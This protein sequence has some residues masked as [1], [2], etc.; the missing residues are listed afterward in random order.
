MHFRGIIMLL[1][2]RQARMVMLI[3]TLLTGSLLSY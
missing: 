1:T 2:I 3:W